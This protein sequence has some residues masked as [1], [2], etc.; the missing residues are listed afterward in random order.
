MFRTSS[1]SSPHVRL[2]AIRTDHRAGCNAS[3]QRSLDGG[4]R[5]QDRLI[6]ATSIVQRGQHRHLFTRQT[7]L[8]RAP[9][10]RTCCPIFWRIPIHPTTMPLERPQKEGFIG[11][12]HTREDRRVVIGGCG[13]EAMPPAPDGDMAHADAS[14][15]DVA[16]RQMIGHVAEI[17]APL[18]R[19]PRTR[20]RRTSQDVVRAT[21]STVLEPLPAVLVLAVLDNIP[22]GA[23]RACP[24]L[25]DG[26]R[27]M[28]ES[29]FR[30]LAG[31]NTLD[32]LFDFKDLCRRCVGGDLG[33]EAVSTEST[34]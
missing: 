21:A 3:M 17:L 31:D 8:D 28:D 34:A 2:G 7:T 11:F 19:F 29:D 33:L 20:H 18:L 27:A 22:T 25:N 6:D 32:N 13:E 16:N 30:H 10:T 9:C 5:W 1:H 24:D 23:T 14:L 15:D 4:Q 12:D 26:V